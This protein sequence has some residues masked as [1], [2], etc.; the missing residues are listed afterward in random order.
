MRCIGKRCLLV[1]SSLIVLLSSCGPY[2]SDRRMIAEFHKNEAE[3]TALFEQ[4]KVW[5]TRSWITPTNAPRLSA[6]VPPLSE[7]QAEDIQTQMADLGVYAINVEPELGYERNAFGLYMKT[8]DQYDRNGELR[9]IDPSIRGKGYAYLEKPLPSASCVFDKNLN[10]I[11]LAAT[12][13]G[14]IYRHVEG[15][16]Y[17]FL[18]GSESS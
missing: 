7:A 6:F 14:L 17:L 18:K 1:V 3:F 2:P 5:E 16:W 4:V 13:S 15:N 9:Q 10:R 12:C 8:E 11:D